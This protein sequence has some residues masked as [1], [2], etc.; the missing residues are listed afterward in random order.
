[1]EPRGNSLIRALERVRQTQYR[2]G[3]FEEKNGVYHKK[4]EEVYRESIASQWMDLL[5]YSGNAPCA[6][7]RNRNKLAK[8]VSLRY[9]AF[10]CL[11][12]FF[13]VW[14]ASACENI[15]KLRDSV[16]VWSCVRHRRASRRYSSA[17]TDAGG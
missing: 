11:I 1:M 14:T 2:R 17:F 5:R 9:I 10:A 15:S 3:S 13:D 4:A 12:R 7:Y 8:I 6:G 16:C